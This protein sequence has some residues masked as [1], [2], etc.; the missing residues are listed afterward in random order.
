MSRC[1]QL[2]PILEREVK[3]QNGK[4]LLAKLNSDDHPQVAQQLQVKSLPTVLLVHQGKMVD[5][6]VGFQGEAA[7][8][9]FVQKAAGLATN[10]SEGEPDLSQVQTMLSNVLEVLKM[11]ATTSTSAGSTGPSKQEIEQL[12]SALRSLSEFQLPPLPSGTSKTEKRRQDEDAAEMVRAVSL[13]GLVR[14]ALINQDH[15]AAKA[16]CDVL[17]TKYSQKLLENPE[18]KAALALASLSADEPGQGGNEKDALME[19]IA[20]NS[21]DSESR[22]RLAKVYYNQGEHTQAMD[23]A[24]ELLKRDRA[25]GDGAARLLLIDIFNA[26]GNTDQVKEA[27]RKMTSILLN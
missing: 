23:T 2:A 3:A 6:F 21:A 22:L 13:S 27:R 10:A 7:V 18:I 16:V 26:L 17:R 14:C 25:Y 12:I 24:L 15:A 9:Q 19:A 8:V 5:Q 1:K 11:A 4:V 20:K